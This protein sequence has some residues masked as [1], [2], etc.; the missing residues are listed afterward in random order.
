[1][2]AMSTHLVLKKKNLAWPL[3]CKEG[4]FLKTNIFPCSLNTYIY[5][6]THEY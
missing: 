1:L 5:Y 4:K 2:N 6:R 3:F